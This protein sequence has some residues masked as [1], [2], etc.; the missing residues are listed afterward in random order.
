MLNKKIYSLQKSKKTLFSVLKWYNKKEKKLSEK[1]KKELQGSMK[2]LETFLLEKNKNSASNEAKK[3]EELSRRYIPRT[4]LEKFIESGLTL[5]VAIFIAIL[6]RQMWFE[7]FTIPTGSMRPTLKEKDFLIVSKTTFSVNKPTP[8]GHFYFNDNLI[9]RG[10][11]TIISTA[12]MDVKDNDYMYFFIIPG[13][14]QFIKRLIAKPGDTLYFYGGQIYGIDKE[15]N[16]IDEFRNNKWFTNFEHIPFIRFEGSPAFSQSGSYGFYDNITLRQMNVPIAQL[17]S[18]PTGQF[19]LLLATK[20]PPFS[21]NFSANDY[22]DIWGFKN[23]AMA[24]VI[25]KKQASEFNLLDNSSSNKSDYYLELTHHPSIKKVRMER[26]YLGRLMPSLTYSTSLIPLDNDHLYKIFDNLYTCRFKVKNGILSHTG[27]GSVKLPEAFSPKINNVPDGCY[28]FQN[29]I[30][31]EVNFAGLTKKLPLSHPI[32][33]KSIPKIVTLFNLGIE[34]NTLFSPSEKNQMLRPARYGYFR[35]NDLYLMG[36][37][38][39]TSGDP[40]LANF[41]TNEKRK[42]FPFSDNENEIISENKINKETILKYG[43]KIPEGH[44]LLLGDNHAMS[45]DCRDF[46]FVPTQNLRGKASFVY[47]PPQERAG[48]IFQPSSSWFILPKAIIFS[49]VIIVSLGCYIYYRKKH[50]LPIKFKK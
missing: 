39:F 2:S 26:D 16:E 33:E 20:N 17:K 46:G 50:S 49:L 23:Y 6:V 30:A 5:L 37:P 15:G 45:S 36:H 9:K 44:Y 21:S 12:D 32:Y 42:E 40:D 4:F 18:S 3:L 43:L 10:D 28:E 41:I 48:K 25:T 8:T 1:E 34:M 31:Y 22:Y 11:I 38:I 7:N 29:G 19:G 47:W 27:Y 14:K 24:R 35:H 13:K